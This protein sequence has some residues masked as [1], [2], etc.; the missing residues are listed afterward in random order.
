MTEYDRFMEWDK[1]ELVECILRL[2]DSIKEQK[3]EIKKLK[4]NK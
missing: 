2:N 4:N 1:N 3:K